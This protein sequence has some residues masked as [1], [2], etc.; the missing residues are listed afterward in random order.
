VNEGGGDPKQLTTDPHADLA[1]AVSP[2]GKFVVF[3]SDRGGRA[4]IWKMD[5]DGGNQ[6][7][8]ADDGMFPQFSPDSQWVIYSLTGMGNTRIWRVPTEGGTPTQITNTNSFSPV[9]SPDGKSIA[10]TYTENSQRKIGICPFEGGAEIKALTVPG[11][12][13]NNNFNWSPD[14]SALMY[15]YVRDGAS[16][17]WRQ[18][19]DG[20]PP[21][22]VTNFKTERP[23]WCNW[24]PDGKKLGC[25]IGPLNWDVILISDF[26]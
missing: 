8:L 9:V 2:D 19:L 21:K 15:R 18:P 4:A 26:R 6:T 12:M 13:Q 10:Y 14:S 22:Q 16:N 20:G 7:Q 23:W 17:V 5:M 11:G 25:A 24:S 3:S 1:P